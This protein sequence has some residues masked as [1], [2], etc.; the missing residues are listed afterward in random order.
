MLSFVESEAVG[1][2]DE[3]IGYLEQTQS[4]L[5]RMADTVGDIIAS[6]ESAHRQHSANQPTTEQS[7]KQPTSTDN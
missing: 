4:E 7:T 2:F 1:L 3:S 6:I 5:S